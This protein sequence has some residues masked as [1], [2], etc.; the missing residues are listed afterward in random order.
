MTGD[1]VTKSGLVIPESAHLRHLPNGCISTSS[2]SW[3]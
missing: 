3:M 2:R 1:I